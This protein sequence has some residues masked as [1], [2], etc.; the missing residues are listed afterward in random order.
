[1]HIVRRRSEIVCPVIGRIMRDVQFGH[2]KLASA[3]KLG[4]WGLASYELGQV[5]DK[6]DR[7]C[8]ALPKHS[9]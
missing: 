2:I 7:R 4:S 9:D 8:P 5:Q 6:L 3:G 1:M